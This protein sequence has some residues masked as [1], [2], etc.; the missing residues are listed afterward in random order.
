MR[1]RRKLKP[2]SIDSYYERHSCEQIEQ[3]ILQMA[4][5]PFSLI[6]SAIRKSYPFGEKKGK[7][8]KTWNRILLAYE[9][10]LLAKERA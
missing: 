2:L 3:V 5:K 7:P 9:A 1:R 4:G 10:Q 8:Y 6:R